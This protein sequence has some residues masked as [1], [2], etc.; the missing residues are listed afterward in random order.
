MSSFLPCVP[1]PPAGC[2][3][4]GWGY[5]PITRSGLLEKELKD[6]RRG[7]LSRPG[8]S[9]K[10]TQKCPYPDGRWGA[11]EGAL[12]GVPR[13]QF[14][15]GPCGRWGGQSWK[16]GVCLINS[17][18]MSDREFLAWG[19]HTGAVVSHGLCGCGPARTCCVSQVV[20]LMSPFQDVIPYQCPS[21]G[22]Q[23]S[24]FLTPLLPLRHSPQ[25]VWTRRR[26]EG[27]GSLSSE[28]PS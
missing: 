10:A 1:W 20:P 11:H 23:P 3:D 18:H 13:P 25:G 28:T 21:H 16:A 27:H 22:S 5:S 12:L 8:L 9:V 24:G 15:G 14:F 19:G 7:D 17:S 26:E 6:G 2:Q 4:T